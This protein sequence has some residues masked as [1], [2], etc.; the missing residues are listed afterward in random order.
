MTATST[1]DEQRRD[2]ERGGEAADA[3]DGEAGEHPAQP[4]P[5]ER[6]GHP[7]PEQ[8]EPEQVDRRPGD[9]D[10]E[11]RAREHVVGC[12]ITNSSPTAETTIPATIR[13]CR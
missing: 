11:L 9:D 6:S 13:T 8:H 7:Q 5:A 3:G 4:A 2:D 12:A 10:R 1:R